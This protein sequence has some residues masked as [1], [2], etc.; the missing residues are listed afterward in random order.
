MDQVQSVDLVGELGVFLFEGGLA[1]APDGTAY[2]VN[3][4][5]TTTALL[6]LGLDTGVA[7]VVNMLS[8][9]HDI[10]GLGWRSDGLLVGLD[11]TNDQLVTIDPVTLAIENIDELDPWPMMGSVGGMVLLGDAAYFATGGPLAI[12]EGSNSL[13]T[14][15]PVDGDPSWVGSFDGTITGTG[16]SGLAIIPE[17][18]T[19]GLVLIGCCAVLRRRGR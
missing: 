18:A 17:P 12:S 11:G 7:T 16:I 13:Y 2:A 14:F 4:G 1:F 3:G 5:V 6:K 10:G 8:G 9:R 19:L 15:D